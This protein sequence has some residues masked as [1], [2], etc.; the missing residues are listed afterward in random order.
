MSKQANDILVF[1]GIQKFVLVEDIHEDGGSKNDFSSSSNRNPFCLAEM[2]TFLLRFLLKRRCISQKGLFEWFH[3]T[4]KPR[5]GYLRTRRLA[6]PFAESL[7]RKS[8]IK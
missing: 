4:R 5:S 8:K 2:M 6:Q 1:L 3:K 7:E